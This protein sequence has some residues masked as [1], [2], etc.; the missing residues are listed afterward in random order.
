M[1]A[2]SLGHV[3]F[4]TRRM[5]VAVQ[6]VR[7]QTPRQKQ[8]VQAASRWTGRAPFRAR[9]AESNGHS[10]PQTARADH[11]QTFGGWEQERSFRYRMIF[12]WLRLTQFYIRSFLDEVEF[13][14]R[15]T[16]S[17]YFFFAALTDSGAIS[18]S[19]NPETSALSNFPP[20]FRKR[21]VFP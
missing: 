17:S 6:E 21:T 14:W 10:A 15:K 16:C 9:S 3:W 19:F 2:P 4:V 8:Q 7:H 20:L 1:C 13:Q 5:H 12:S 18:S 11:E